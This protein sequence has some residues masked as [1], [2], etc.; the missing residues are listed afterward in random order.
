MKKSQKP[1]LSR[2][3]GVKGQKSKVKK[4]EECFWQAIEI[5]RSQQAKSLELRAVIRLSRVWQTQG[6]KA[7]ARQVLEEC[8]G[9]F[10]EG[11]DTVDLQA[12]QGL[13]VE[14]KGAE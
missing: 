14:L 4:A 6:K 9:W 3:E 8:Y 7:E 5:A 10:T 11:F 13:L 1:V 12:A 2:V